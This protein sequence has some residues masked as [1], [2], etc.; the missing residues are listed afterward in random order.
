M[1]TYLFKIILDLGTEKQTVFTSASNENTA[2]K[3][4]CDFFNCPYRAVIEI[5]QFLLPK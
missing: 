4:V 5:N 1:R 3:N 2:I